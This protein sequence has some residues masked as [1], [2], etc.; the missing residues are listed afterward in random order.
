MT[1]TKA[2][3]IIIEYETFGVRTDPAVLLIMGFGAQLTWW[4]VKVCEG[5]SKEGYF[6]VRYDNRDVGLS[7]SFDEFAPGS[8]AYTL[9]DMAADAAGLLDALDISAAHVVG[10]SMGGM[11]AQHLA[12]DFPERVKSLVSIMSTT[13]DR[14]VGHASPEALS[15]LLSPPPTSRD[16]AVELRVSIQKVIGSPGFPF[17]EEELREKAGAAHDRADNPRGRARQLAAI[18]AQTDRTAALGAVQA[19][20]LVVHGGDDSL[21]HSSGGVATAAAIP[22]AVLKII[23]GMGHEIPPELY[24]E[25]IADLSG[26]FRRVDNG[27]R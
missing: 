26:H 24:D 19:P 4:D 21:V 8:L 12:I 23:P 25:V 3:G 20:T 9:D 27:V 7:T 14:T 2:N 13:G 16:E 18:Q 11:I 1:A 22:G 10:A 15:A 17:H 6:V 5:L